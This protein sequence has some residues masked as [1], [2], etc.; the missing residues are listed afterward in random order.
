MQVPVNQFAGVEGHF[1][2]FIN[3][4]DGSRDQVADFKNLILDVGLDAAMTAGSLDAQM[5]ACRVGG[6]STPPAVTQTT[7]VNHIGSTTGQY[8]ARAFSFSSPVATRTTYFRFGA[9]AAAG[10][11]SE[12]GVAPAASGNMW[13]RALILDT[14][15]QP[16]TITVLPT[17]TLD[18]VYTL[19]LTLSTAAVPGSFVIS[20][21]THTTNQYLKATPQ[22]VTADVFSRAMF[23][24]TADGTA[25]FYTAV[26]AFGNSSNGVQGTELP[27]IGDNVWNTFGFGHA[28]GTN[29]ADRGTR[30]LVGKYATANLAAL[31]DLAL[32]QFGPYV[33]V[34]FTPPIPLDA[35]QYVQLNFRMTLQ[36]L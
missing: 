11:L 4:E 32:N 18:V 10:N 36:R 2:L 3:R 25:R 17:E 14:L 13:S 31:D 5:L 20:G 27:P 22:L 19:R 6:G 24:G 35:T 1:T 29:Y 33:K 12:V 9:G 8:Q 26:T 7:L 28:V 30:S 23:A 34:Q 15:G 16:T 21:T